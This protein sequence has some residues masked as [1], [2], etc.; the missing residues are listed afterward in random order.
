MIKNKNAEIGWSFIVKL[1]IGL[2]VLMALIFIAAGGKT[3]FSEIL[4][5]IGES[6]G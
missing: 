1:V 4:A 2:L 6:F 5:K 3:W